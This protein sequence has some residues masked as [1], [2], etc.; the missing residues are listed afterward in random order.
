MSSLD[1]G[2]AREYVREEHADVVARVD[3][4][5]DAVAAS[6]DEDSVEDAAA[7]SAPLEACLAEA[8]VLDELPGVLAGAVDAA[9]GELRAPPVAA[10]PYVVV[11]SRGPLLRAT[12]DGGRLVVR[13][14]AFRVADGG[15]YE[16]AETAVRAALR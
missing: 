3:S 10:P 14:D 4:C 2:A 15:R 13:F 6:W 7:V 11:T 8:G 9:G 12:L 5:A 1:P 16:R